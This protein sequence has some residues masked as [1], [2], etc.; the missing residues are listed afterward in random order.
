ML[1][2]LT[3]GADYERGRPL[4]SGRAAQHNEPIFGSFGVMG[5]RL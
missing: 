5:Y 4:V 2:K 1:A 3:E